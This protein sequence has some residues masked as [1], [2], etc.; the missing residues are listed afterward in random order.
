MHIPTTRTLGL[1]LTGLFIAAHAHADD[2]VR[3]DF[4][5]SRSV[6]YRA[7]PIGADD[8]D[9][10]GVSARIESAGDGFVVID[11]HLPLKDNTQRQAL[12][13]AI[14]G[15]R[16]ADVSLHVGGWDY[17]PMAS[18][19][20]S[21]R[22]TTVFNSAFA[23]GSSLVSVMQNAMD[24]VGRLVF[25]GVPLDAEGPWTITISGV[26]RRIEPPATVHDFPVSPAARVD[27]V[28]RSVRRQPVYA[29]GAGQHNLNRIV[30]T[31]PGGALLE[32]SLDLRSTLTQADPGL[33]C[34]ATCCRAGLRFPIGGVILRDRATGHAVPLLTATISGSAGTMYSSN[35]ARTSSLHV[36]DTT[37]QQVTLLYAVPDSL[38]EFDLT[39]DGVTLAHAKVGGP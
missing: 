21:G 27:A 32:I 20:Q 34:L 1:I 9:R 6:A 4:E 37:P 22:Q 14:S 36:H 19:D 7:L 26:E 31:N 11:I 30:Y 39:L 35:F 38:R 10:T 23:G 25:D 2:P 17:T 29:F 12:Y 24:T 18:F 15:L 33:A 16:V 28:I 13:T 5:A 3:L 8:G